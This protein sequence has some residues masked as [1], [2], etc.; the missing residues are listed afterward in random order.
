MKLVQEYAGHA[1]FMIT[2]NTYAHTDISEKQAE[3]DSITEL[4]AI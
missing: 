4:L 2:A 3:I 1:D